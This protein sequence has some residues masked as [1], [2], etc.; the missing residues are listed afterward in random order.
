MVCKPIDHERG[1]FPS[2]ESG[3]RPSSNG[4]RKMRKGA[5]APAHE[6]VS[7]P[8]APHGYLAVHIDLTIPANS[9]LASFVVGSS[10]GQS[11][12]NSDGRKGVS[13]RD[14]HAHLLPG[15]ALMLS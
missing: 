4:C 3:A 6:I 12:G 13:S 14:H 10:F 5:G 8:A 2:E 1:S 11:C 15:P 7:L 9:S